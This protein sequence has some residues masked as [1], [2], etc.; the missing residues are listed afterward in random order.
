M[1]GLGLVIDERRQLP[2]WPLAGVAQVDVEGSRA[3]AIERRDLVVASR[4]A[5]FG[6][7]RDTADLHRCLRQDSEGLWQ[8]RLQCLDEPV[9]VIEYLLSAGIGVR[10]L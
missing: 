5:G 4:R 6:I 8:V 2:A 10:E 1:P 3:R 9:A 7:G